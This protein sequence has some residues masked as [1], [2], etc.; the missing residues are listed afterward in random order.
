MIN[1][2]DVSYGSYVGLDIHVVV[3]LPVF[4]TLSSHVDWIRSW[5]GIQ[6]Q[7]CFQWKTNISRPNRY[8]EGRFIYYTCKDVFII[9]GTYISPIEGICSR[10]PQI[11]Y[12]DFIYSIVYSLMS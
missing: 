10:L 8:G 7:Y 5:Y 2:I 12:D 3:S 11:G 1:I 4:L 9:R 6:Y